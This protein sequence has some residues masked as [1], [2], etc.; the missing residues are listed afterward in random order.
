MNFRR[1]L[2]A[3]CVCSTSCSCGAICLP[4]PV[5][6]NA[7]LNGTY[8][9]VTTLKPYV[10]FAGG[11]QLGS[12]RLIFDGKGVFSGEQ[13]YEG[14]RDKLSGT[15]QIDPDGSGFAYLTSV[16]PDSTVTQSEYSLK[17]QNDNKI[18]GGV[19]RTACDHRLAQRRSPHSEWTACFYERSYPHS[20]SGGLDCVSGAARSRLSGTFEKRRLGRVDVVPGLSRRGPDMV[21][22][23]ES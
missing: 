10:K 11:P 18:F 16:G 9:V 14:E 8:E 20:R 23:R 22:G 17:I 3:L 2:V 19:L 6:S 5:W 7:S 15:Y 21:G 1:I 13:T 4:H 12:G